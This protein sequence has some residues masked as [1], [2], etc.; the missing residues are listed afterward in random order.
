MIDGSFFLGTR[1]FII[2]FSTQLTAALY[3]AFIAL[4]LLLVFTVVLRRQ[5]LAL[6][7][8]LILTSIISTLLGGPNL[9]G[10]PFSVLGALL[11]VIV[12]Y[13]Y[14]L[15]AA[16]SA[17]FVAHLM[18]FYPMTTELTA[19]YATNFTI[20]L[21]ICVALVAYGFYTSLAGQPLFGEKLLQD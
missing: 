7:A 16:I 14:G 9:I 20:A 11:L 15:L 8:L 1:Y 10:T 3:L 2:G 4:F 17:L 5:W 21:A 13:R 12:L 18:I 19:W 6:G